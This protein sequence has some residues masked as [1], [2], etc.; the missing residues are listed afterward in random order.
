MNSNSRN[1]MQQA[2]HIILL[3]YESGSADRTVL[4][5]CRISLVIGG[6][7]L[8]GLEMSFSL[9]IPFMTRSRR[10][11]SWVSKVL[12]FP[13]A[14]WTLQ[15]WQGNCYCWVSQILVCKVSKF[16][17]VQS[18]PSSDISC[19]VIVKRG[20]GTLETSWFI[21]KKLDMQFLDSWSAV[22]LQARGMWLAVKVMSKYVVKSHKQRRSCI[23]TRSFDDP[24]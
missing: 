21:V 6:Q 12:C 2:A 14:T 23:T 9:R 18:A 7:T 19:E 24:F 22:V 17:D 13:L 8:G 20:A 3:K 11:V 4:I 5:P 16:N 10:G 15:Q 1:A